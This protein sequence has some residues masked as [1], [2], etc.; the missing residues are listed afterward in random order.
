MP[1]RYSSDALPI[2][3]APCNQEAIAKKCWGQKNITVTVIRQE[4]K[5][6]VEGRESSVGFSERLVKGR[7]SQ[8][9]AAA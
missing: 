1:K 9:K 4:N 3:K 2:T 8:Y 6:L 5:S 7:D